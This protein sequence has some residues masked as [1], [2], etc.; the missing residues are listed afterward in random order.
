MYG[1]GASLGSVA[2]TSLLHADQVSDGAGG[3]RQQQAH[4]PAKAKR[5]IFLMMEGGPSH[6]DTFDP[7]P[8][9]AKRHLDEFNRGGEEESA[10]ASGKRYFVKSPFKFT[11]AGKCG[12]DISDQW[13]HLKDR[14]DDICF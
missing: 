12:A 6:I 2:L 9:L 3:K 11:Q 5:C 10:M 4:F 13:V 7:K 1:L 14:V 8:E